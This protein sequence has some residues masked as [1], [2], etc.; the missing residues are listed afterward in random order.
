MVILHHEFDPPMKTVNYTPALESIWALTKGKPEICIAI[1]DGAA[2]L[3]HPVFER[4]NLSQVGIYGAAE[5]EWTPS[6]HGTHVSSI[7]FGQHHTSVKGIAPHVKGVVI[8]IFD[9]EAKQNLPRATQLDLARAI[10]KAIEI[11]A[12][13][14][15]ISAGELSDHGEPEP[16][17]EQVLR[18][19]EENQ[20]LVVAAAGNDGCACIHIPAAR[21][22]VLAVGAMDDTGRPLGSSNWG[23]AYQFSGLLAPGKEIFGATTGHNYG[24]KTGTSFATPFV[25]GVT[26]LLLSLQIEING[27]S[28]PLIIRDILLQTAT[29]CTAKEALDCNRFLK[30][31]IHVQRALDKILSGKKIKPS[32]SAS[33]HTQET[34]STYPYASFLNLKNPFK[35]ENIHEN[36]N[37]GVLEESAQ[38]LTA[39]V[40]LSELADVNITDQFPSLEKGSLHDGSKP[41]MSLSALEPSC[42]GDSNCGCGNKKGTETT[43]AQLQKV[44]ALGTI[45]YDFVSES[46]R[47]SFLQHINANLNDPKVMIK[48]FSKNLNEAEGLIWTLE[49]EGT[50]I[51]AIHP[52]GAFAKDAYQILVNFLKEQLEE[53]VERVAVPGLV[54]GKLTL[55]NGQVVPAIVPTIRGMASWSTTALVK[56]LG[57]NNPAEEALQNF[58][59]RIYHEFR[60]FGVTAH[61]RAINFAATNAFQAN[62]VFQKAIAEGMQLTDIQV[63]KS[64]VVRPGVDG[65]DVQLSFFDPHNRFEK[66]KKM[67]R[68]TVDVS[69]VV[70]V[71]I[72]AV[73]SWFVY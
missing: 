69:D 2:D 27:A 30:G 73:R 48:H 31:K 9:F 10:N 37:V 45:G 36:Q 72:G 67:Y 18:Q 6:D 57:E 56:A 22:G 50:P 49:Q 8:P 24:T 1:I 70:P 28:N 43:P 16:L 32:S 35:M 19:C 53:G 3:T 38:E 14:I 29:P 41:G 21:P 23:Q 5:S 66:A 17:L 13:I 20:I 71:S 60:N 46:R 7:I 11:G 55:L 25:T 39:Q 44:Y 12:N 40:Q 26:A 4:A 47:D 59:E 52:H 54:A 34:F 42:G 61:E 58:L 64:P 63:V 33:G 51:Y 68:F 15:N 65:W 62:S